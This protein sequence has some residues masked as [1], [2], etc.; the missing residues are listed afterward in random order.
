MTTDGSPN[1]S[2]L[3]AVA[4]AATSNVV[5]QV[6]GVASG[7]LV[8]SF[9]EP[10]GRGAYAAA[11]AW[12]GALSVLGA[13]GITSSICYFVAA[14]RNPA[15]AVL[16]TG[17]RLLLLLGLGSGFLGLALTPLLARGDDLLQVA[18]VIVFVALPLVF[19]GGTWMF[20]LQGA[21][22][23]RWARVRL[24]QPVA[25]VLMLF[26]LGWLDRLT[27]A[28]A[29]AAFVISV[30]A[31][32]LAARASWRRLGSAPAAGEARLRG[33][34]VAYGLKSLA[35]QAP[36]LLNSRVDQLVLSLAVSLA[37]LGRY[38]VAVS[39][40]MLI[41]ALTAAFGVVAMPRIAQ[42]RNQALGRPG[43]TA[44]L[45]AIGTLGTGALG[46][47]VVVAGTPYLLPLILDD[48]YQGVFP[49]VAVLAP[50]AALLGLNQ[51]LADVLRGYDQ[52]LLVA[53]AEGVA[54]V[55][56]VALLAIFI[57]WL[58]ILG[59]AISSTCSYA[60]ATVLLL[61]AIRQRIR[62]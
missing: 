3:R 9:L 13:L 5:L 27:V 4:H 30:L 60:V 38:A 17:Q 34:M 15:A 46:A 62:K 16:G 22:L 20:A 50:G 40:T 44:R 36:F 52:A 41:T 48:S 53:R 1:R 24:V 61:V 59:A 35:A 37:D 39:L 55:V 58:G 43:D 56:T 8:A 49:L 26:A 23:G 31:Q 29:L 28:A 19:V 57:P 11:L 2:Y 47:V 18:Y 32:A 14:G 25:Y 21:D 51:V 33:P 42:E 54:G 45:A 6:L 12:S 7:F 10:S